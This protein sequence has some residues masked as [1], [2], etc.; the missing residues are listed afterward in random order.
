MYG[1]SGDTDISRPGRGW[2]AA[3]PLGARASGQR[4]RLPKRAKAPAPA[5]E[6]ES[7][8]GNRADDTGHLRRKWRRARSVCLREA[9]A[10]VAARIKEAVPLR[11]GSRF[12]AVS[13]HSEPL[14][15]ARQS[16][17]FGAN[18]RC[19]GSM[20]R[21]RAKLGM[22]APAVA[23]HHFTSKSELRGPDSWRTSSCPPPQTQDLI[24]SRKVKKMRHASPR[25]HT[26]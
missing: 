7:E 4:A 6:R 26:A 3:A 15:A 14:T 10:R 23:P 16:S 19:G 17:G 9:H 8:E 20:G 22:W 11:Q 13:G 2:D 24:G 21:C 1:A 5:R 18:W 12:C 25:K